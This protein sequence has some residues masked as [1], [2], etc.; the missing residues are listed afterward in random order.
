MVSGSWL[1]AQGAWLMP[2]GSWLNTKRNWAQAPGAWG[3][4]ANGFQLFICIFLSSYTYIFCP[5]LEL[6]TSSVRGG[7]SLGSKLRLLIR[8]E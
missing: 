5:P 4:S 7:G 3:P 1:M 2:Q 8:S 6:S